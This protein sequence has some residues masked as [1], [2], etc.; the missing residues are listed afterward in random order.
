VNLVLAM[1]KLLGHGVA[2]AGVAN[3]VSRLGPKS[4]PVQTGAGEAQAPE[5]AGGCSAARQPAAPAAWLRPQE[6]VLDV[7]V[8]NRGRAL[9]TAAAYIGRA[10][11]LDPA[12]ILRSLLRREEV[13][14][15]ALGQGVAIPHARIAGIA[16]PLTLFMR[17]RN[18]I[19]FGAADGTPVANLLVIMVPVDGDTD[20]HLQLL[21]LVADAFSDRAFRACLAAAT[22][23]IQ[24]EEAFAERAAL[25]G[26]V[27]RRAPPLAEAAEGVC[28]GIGQHPA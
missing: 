5:R 13:G 7:D 10:H 17:L 26:A 2:R 11:G 18:A 28:A 12:P 4:A 27:P 3:P 15:T 14:S 9:E 21:A 25:G 23:A 6:I 19:E 1:N 24:V 8:P 20:D 16:R 22:T